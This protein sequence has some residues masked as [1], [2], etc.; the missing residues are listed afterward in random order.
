MVRIEMPEIVVIGVCLWALF[1][2]LW[3]MSLAYEVKTLR[4]F[5]EKRF[6]DDDEDDDPADYWK[7]GA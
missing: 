2:L 5:I 7:K 1:S 3:T 4:E 6:K